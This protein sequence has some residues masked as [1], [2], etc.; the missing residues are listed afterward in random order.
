MTQGKRPEWLTPSVVA[1]IAANLLPVYGVLFMGW[2][3]F[4]IVFLFWLENVIVGAF[5]VLRIICARPGDPVGCAG[6][7][8][9]I[10]FFCVHYGIFCAVHG[11]FVFALFG[12]GAYEPRGLPTPGFIWN[13]I[14]AEHLT[15]PALALAGSHG[16]SFLFNYIGNG[17]YRTARIKKLFG[18][19]YARVVVLHIAIIFGGFL[20]MALG[21]PVFGL[22]LLV[23]LKIGVDIG[24]HSLE[25]RKMGAQAGATASD[26]ESEP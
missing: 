3:T 11:V 9:A 1:L 15:I 7:L 17:E 8:G 25:H 16:F 14:S 5:N 4:A 23:L 18:Q 6:K 12:H 21:S 19:P 10:P 24:A 22:L 26:D 20:T 13:A 2:D